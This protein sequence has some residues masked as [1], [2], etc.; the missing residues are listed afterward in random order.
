MQ[1]LRGVDLR[2][3]GMDQDDF[4]LIPLR[5]LQRPIA[6]NTDVNAI[7]VSAQDG[8]CTAK[9]KQDIEQLIRERRHITSGKDDDFHR[10]RLGRTG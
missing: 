9:I 5:T 1:A 7:Y 4:V 3:D 10:Q 2:I 8:V 6:G